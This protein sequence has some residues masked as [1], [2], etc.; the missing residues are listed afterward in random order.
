[1]TDPSRPILPSITP[2]TAPTP[3]TAPAGRTRFNTVPKRY[4]ETKPVVIQGHAHRMIVGM[5]VTYLLSKTTSVHVHLNHRVR[6]PYDTPTQKSMK[7]IYL[8]II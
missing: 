6:V 3:G 1:M 2:R 4:E 7:F 5:Y 8:I